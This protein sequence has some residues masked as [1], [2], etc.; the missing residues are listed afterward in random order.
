MTGM[1]DSETVLSE[2]VSAGPTYLSGGRNLLRSLNTNVELSP[3]SIPV[4]LTL[5]LLITPDEVD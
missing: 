3:G 2:H 5:V 4:F 1:S